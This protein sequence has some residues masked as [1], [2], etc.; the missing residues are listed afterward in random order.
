MFVGVEES[1]AETRNPNQERAKGASD[2]RA[3]W[4]PA[5]WVVGTLL[6]Q[7][8]AFVLCGPVIEPEVPSTLR[9]PLSDELAISIK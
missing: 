1:D 9:L 6:T 3:T 2:K 7:R 5:T 8:T 4:A